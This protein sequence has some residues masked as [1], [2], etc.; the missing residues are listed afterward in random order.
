MGWIKKFLFAFVILAIIG[1]LLGDDTTNNSPINNSLNPKSTS[2]NTNL[3]RTN[4]NEYVSES[5]DDLIFDFVSRD[6]QYTDLQKKEMFENYDNKLIKDFAMVKDIDTLSL[7]DGIV[8]RAINPENEFITG[9]TI[10]FKPTEKEKLLKFDKYDEVKFE[11]K[12]TNYNRLLGIIIMD[13]VVK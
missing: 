5:L 13:A 11:G 3:E 2:Q 7:S 1:A 12:I 10:Y 6:S 9:A 8:V 4:Q